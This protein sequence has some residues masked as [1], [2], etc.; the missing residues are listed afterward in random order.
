MKMRKSAIY[1]AIVFIS[2]ILIVGIIVFISTGSVDVN[3]IGSSTFAILL[4][5]FGILMLS[6]GE[7]IKSSLKARKNGILEISLPIPLFTGL[8]L[9]YA[10]IILSTQNMVTGSA[11]ASLLM[12]CF[13][14]SVAMTALCSVLLFEEYMK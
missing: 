11:E 2:I 5:N 3:R 10:G 12:T 8:F 4:V 1:S 6:C 9:S 7:K 13:V 14:G